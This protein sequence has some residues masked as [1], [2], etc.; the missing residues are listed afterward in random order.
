MPV[1][2][3]L[4]TAL[5][6]LSRDGFQVG[7]HS[8]QHHELVLVL[9]GSLLV[10]SA[11]RSLTGSPGSLHVFP[12]GVSH[13]QVCRGAWHTICLLF[14][15]QDDLVCDGPLAIETGEDAMLQ[16]WFEQLC[17]LARDADGEDHGTRD[18]L[19][20]TVLQRIHRLRRQRSS[21][22]DLPAPLVE[23]LTVIGR[24]LDRDLDVAA[25]TRQV[26]LSRSQLGEL[27]RRHIGNAPKRHHAKLR[28][29]RAKA[30]LA[31]PYTTVTAVAQE[32]GFTDLNW[33]VRRFGAEHGMPPGRWQTDVSQGTR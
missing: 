24:Q 17:N 9:R 6:H 4:H 32:L 26:G 14:Q 27:F 20:A 3:S 5:H 30:M 13:D 25:L 11:G 16:T 33:F 7:Q 28:L 22:H 12:S 23:A 18:G 15:A 10:T 19:L 1:A 8:H 29:A 31:N 21:Q 2:P